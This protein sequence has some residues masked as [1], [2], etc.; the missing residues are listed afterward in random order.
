MESD[1]G[2]H[3]FVHLFNLFVIHVLILITR[4]ETPPALSFDVNASHTLLAVGTELVGSDAH[5][6]FWYLLH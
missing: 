4:I 1:Y 5:L 6:Q 2:I 3:A